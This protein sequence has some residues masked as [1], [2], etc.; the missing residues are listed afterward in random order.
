MLETDSKNIIILLD[1]KDH[2]FFISKIIIFSPNKEA[3]ER[4]DII[5]EYFEV[6]KT[7]Q[8]VSVYIT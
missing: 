1:V 6:L 2:T 4:K 5:Y 8:F 3:T 7:G